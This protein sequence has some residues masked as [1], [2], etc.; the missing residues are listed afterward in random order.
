MPQYSMPPQ[1]QQYSG[2]PYMNYAPSAAPVA[3]VAPAK[4]EKPPMTLEEFTK[5]QAAAKPKPVAKAP[6]KLKAGGSGVSIKIGSGKSKSVSIG[7]TKSAAKPATLS[8]TSETE[9]SQTAQTSAPTATDASSQSSTPV[10]SKPPTPVNNA[11]AKSQTTDSPAES[12]AEVVNADQVVTQQAADVDEAL[13]EELY[14]EKDHLSIIFMGHVDAGKSTM[15]GNILLQTG[16]VDKRTMEKYQKEAKDSGN[17]SWWL[18]WALDTDKDERDKGKTVEVGRAPFETEKRRYTILDAPGHKAYVPN[19]IAGAAQADIGILVISARRGEYET[20]FE[21]GGQTRE[22]AMLAKSQGIDRLVIAVNKMDD[23]TVE[24]SKERYD[25]CTTK[26]LNFLKSLGYNKSTDITC[27]PV[28]AQTGYGLLERVPTDVCPWYNGPCLLEF[29]DNV[30]LTDRKLRGPFMMPI[31]ERRRDIGTIVEGKVESGVAKKGDSLLVMPNKVQV[32]LLT[33]YSETEAE[34]N[35]AACGEQVKLRIKGIE[36]EDVQIGFVLCS[37]ANPVHTVTK[38]EA[39][40]SFIDLKSIITAGYSCMMH[41]HTAIEE[42]VFA[43]LLHKLEPSTGR[44]SKKPPQFAKQG[45]R[46]IAVLQTTQNVCLEPF[47]EHKQL[48]RFT[49]RDQGMTIAIGKVTKLL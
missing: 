46:V 36:E 14:N 9:T 25:E 49:L 18:S 43:E 22:H 41:V 35:N 13:L 32:E 16:A 45:M 28:S 38:F 3:P 29:L 31:S 8:A 39:Q 20:G 37:L 34:I 44:K 6:M 30:S 2:N 40:I 48:G 19:M 5:Q 15:G 26:L 21:R 24:W 12:A 47:S 11:P 10:D 4:Q 17:E 33:I 42:V 1:Q 23:I 27:M 7:G